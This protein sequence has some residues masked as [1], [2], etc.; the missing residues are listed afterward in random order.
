VNISHSH[1]AYLSLL[2]LSSYK[3]SREEQFIRK[4]MGEKGKVACWEYGEYLEL[5]ISSL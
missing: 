1:K 4:A 5:R 3:H 2:S